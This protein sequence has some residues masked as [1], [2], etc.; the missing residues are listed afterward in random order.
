MKTNDGEIGINANTTYSNCVDTLETS[1][2]V[3]SIAKW[4]QD[5]GRSTGIVTTTRVTHATPAGAYAHT[6]DRD[7][8]DDNLVVQSGCN[9]DVVDDIAEQ[10]VFGET[11]KN[12]KVIFGG[13]SRHFVN[14]SF[15]EHGTTGRRRDSKHLINEW[16][17]MKTTRKFIRNRQ[18]LINVNASDV[19]EIMGLFNGDHIS[20]YIDIVRDK[21]EEVMP[22]LTDMTTK[23]IEILERDE[24]GYFLLVE[25]GRIDHGHHRT[26]AKH[27]ISEAVEFSRAIEAALKLVDL[28]ETLIV[29]TADHGHVM[30]MAGYAVSFNQ[31]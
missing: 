26:Q 23:A 30:T 20:Y 21:Q 14:S 31:G 8:E 9:S 6:T 13:G 17:N 2:H 24:K 12:F 16:T 28:E 27:A 29:V 5:E 19:D 11:G 3:T 18:E 15:T 4:F 10:L 1:K 22:T 7:W 25:G